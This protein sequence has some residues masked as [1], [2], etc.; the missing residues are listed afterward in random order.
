MDVQ[1]DA[2]TN[3]TLCSRFKSRW[4]QF[5]IE[6]MATNCKYI[7][8][9]ML[10]SSIQCNYKLVPVKYLLKYLF[11]DPIFGYID[12]QEPFYHFP[13]KHGYFLLVFLSFSFFK[14]IDGFYPSPT[15]DILRLERFGINFGNISSLG[16][17]HLDGTIVGVLSRKS[18]IEVFPFF[19]FN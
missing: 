10:L 3:I 7:M 12:F 4:Q 14:G 1:G 6:R 17:I 9:Q 2:V 19:I 15:P 18:F 13:T 5:N 16:K 8:V 11:Y